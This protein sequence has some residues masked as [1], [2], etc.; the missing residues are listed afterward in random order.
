MDQLQTFISRLF[1]LEKPIDKRLIWAIAGALALVAYLIFT[2]MN[3]SSAGARVKV[4]LPNAAQ[5]SGTTAVVKAPTIFVHVV[6]EVARPGIYELPSSSRVVDAI[7]AASGFNRK[8]DQA[9]INLARA[10]TD[11][12]Q[13]NVARLGVSNDGT[14]GA[15]ANSL[16]S[17]NTASEKQLEDLPSIGPTL[18]ARIIDWRVANGGFKAKTDLLKVSGIGDSLFGK[19]KDLVSL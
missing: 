7:F 13:I 9:S 5:S 11:G 19:I 1:K 12:E 4:S 10:I 18:A 8:A 2:G 6:G 17:L 3:D 16:L 14:L 15:K